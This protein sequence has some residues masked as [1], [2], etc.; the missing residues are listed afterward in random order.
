MSAN[1]F[2]PFCVF[3]AVEMGLWNL[4]SFG[5]CELATACTH[6][7]VAQQ[8]VLE[9]NKRGKDK[10][11]HQQSNHKQNAKHHHP[12]LG[13]P[14][15][16]PPFCPQN[17]AHSSPLHGCVLFLCSSRFYLVYCIGVV[18]ISQIY[19]Y[20]Y[21][22]SL[23]CPLRRN[24]RLAYSS[25]RHTQGLSFDVMKGPPFSHPCSASFP[26]SLPTANKRPGAAMEKRNPF[27]SFPA[28]S[29]PCRRR[30]RRRHN[31]KHSFSF[32]LQVDTP[33]QSHPIPSLVTR[34]PLG[35]P[36][37]TFSLFSF[38]IATGILPSQI[39]P[40]RPTYSQFTTS[41]LFLFLPPSLPPSLPSSP[42]PT[43]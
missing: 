39:K 2:Q 43:R 32:C 22:H 40:F 33:R 3:W 11:K 35:R 25:D 4:F 31:N 13:L 28:P 21:M 15:H 26:F 23:L 42:L 7:Q 27:F 24:R 36:S 34:L 5:V 16:H 14:D 10:G 38:E 37:F 29:S 6:A 8:V 1:A 41:S 19:S 18:I 30:R 12:L 17:P 9:V 20:G